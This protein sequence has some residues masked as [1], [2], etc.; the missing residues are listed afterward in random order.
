M[1]FT[2]LALSVVFISV[3]FYVLY[4]VVRVAVR[5]GILLAEE[6][7]QSGENPPFG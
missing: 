6:E 7:K 5:D 3:L 1:D 2:S 4:R